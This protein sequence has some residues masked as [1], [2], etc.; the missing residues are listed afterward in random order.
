[1]NARPRTS[2]DRVLG[3]A[4]TSDAEIRAL[5]ARAWLERGVV[6]LTAEDRQRMPEWTRLAIEGEAVRLYGRRD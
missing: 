3:V 2:L 4:P 5:A 6:V 1:M